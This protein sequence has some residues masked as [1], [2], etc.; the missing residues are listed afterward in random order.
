MRFTVIVFC[1]SQTNSPALLGQGS[2]GLYRQQYLIGIGIVQDLNVGRHFNDQTRAP[3]VFGVH[4][5]ANGSSEV[6][7]GLWINETSRAS[8][9]LPLD[10]KADRRVL[11]DVF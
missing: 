1:S 7:F 8:V 10:Q 5:G 2:T 3:V 11:A 4:F 6:R 9:P